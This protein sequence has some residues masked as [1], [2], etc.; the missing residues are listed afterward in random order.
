MRFCGIHLGAVQNQRNLP[1]ISWGWKSYFWNCFH[2]FRG[3]QLNTIIVTDAVVVGHFTLQEVVT[4]CTGVT[5]PQH[6]FM[7]RHSIYSVAF[8]KQFF[9]HAFYSSW[10][11]RNKNNVMSE[12]VSF[13]IVCHQSS[14]KNIWN[15][16][17]QICLFIHRR[18]LVRC[19]F[20]ER[21]W[22][23]LCCVLFK[24]WSCRPTLCVM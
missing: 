18:V 23:G 6:M 14:W 8:I 1:F 15:K 10:S 19:I 13:K 17:H 11:T 7:W 2:I 3:N 4:W 12:M 22:Q 20:W 24:A 16:S 21:S 9:Y 5:F